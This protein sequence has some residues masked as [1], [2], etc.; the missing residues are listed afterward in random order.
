MSLTRISQ[1]WDKNFTGWLAKNSEH[2]QI[3]AFDSTLPIQTAPA[4]LLVIQD[5]L[6]HSKA[7]I[8]V[9]V[10]A[11]EKDPT[12]V[13]QLQI[14]ASINNRKKQPVQNIQQGL[15]MLGYERVNSI[16]LQHSLLSL[17]NQQYFPLQKKLLT[18]NQ[19]FVSVAGQLAK[20]TK[21]VSP[22]L[23]YSAANFLVSR[24]FTL[25]AI[26]TLV[27]WPQPKFTT[28]KVMDLIEIKENEYLKNGTVLLAKAWHQNNQILDALKHYDLILQ[29][30]EV[31]RSTRQFCYLI[32]LSLAFAQEYYFS[33]TTHCKETAAYIKTGLIELGISQ[34]E[35]I[36]MM[37]DITESTNVFCELD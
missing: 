37:A 27:H 35:L 24:L 30:E 6:N 33:G 1:W 36:G 5:Q 19:F 34:K 3:A 18:F 21:L 8:A 20:R 13:Q 29:N 25:T 17:L 9:I 14:S 10:K 2:Q 32:G 7:D 12:Y 11:I 23:V 15:A 28:F 26:R 16:L 22:E 4:S 31:A